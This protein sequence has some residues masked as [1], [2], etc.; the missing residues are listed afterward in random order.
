MMADNTP[1]NQR[2]CVNV[3]WYLSFYTRVYDVMRRN[4]NGMLINP[5]KHVLQCHS[6]PRSALNTI[7]GKYHRQAIDT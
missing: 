1:A 5:R 2:R 7:K 4:A 3:M 6:S